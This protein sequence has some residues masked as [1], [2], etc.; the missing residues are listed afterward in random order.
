MNIDFMN[1]IPPEVTSFSTMKNLYIHEG[2]IV[3]IVV[4]GKSRDYK[5]TKFIEEENKW[6]VEKLP[7]QEIVI[8]IV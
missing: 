3:K 2:D 8:E 4:D 7:N 5:I 1:K 6:C